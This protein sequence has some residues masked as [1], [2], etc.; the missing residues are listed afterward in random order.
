MAETPDILVWAPKARRDLIDIWK[1]FA[2]VASEETADNL[3]RQID[4]TVGRLMRYPFSGR[5]RED[6]EPG[7]R[8]ILVRPHMVM[9]R[10]KGDTL[11]ILRILHE[12]Q[13][14]SAM[15]AKAPRP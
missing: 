10:T 12:R 5:P 9:Y 13:D 4:R 6:I 1:Y 2:K 3:L 8:S 15:V 11:E 7:L 14:A